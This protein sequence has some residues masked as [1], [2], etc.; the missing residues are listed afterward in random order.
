MSSDSEI[1]TADETG[2]LTKAYRS[3]SPRYT[4]RKN[5]EMDSIGWAIFLGMLVL[6]VPLLPFLVIVWVLERG[7]RAVAGRRDGD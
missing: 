6:L 5:A 1:Q 2:V 7:I 4:S 3:V